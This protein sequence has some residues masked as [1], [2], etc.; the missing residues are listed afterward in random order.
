MFVMMTMLSFAHS[1]SEYCFSNGCN[2]TFTFR[3]WVGKSAGNILEASHRT[4]G[5]KTWQEQVWNQ[6]VNGFDFEFDINGQEII[7]DL[8]GFG[9]NDVTTLYQRWDDIEIN[10]GPLVSECTRQRFKAGYQSAHQQFYQFFDYLGQQFN[11][12]IGILVECFWNLFSAGTFMTL[13]TSWYLT[14]NTIQ[15]LP[16]WAIVCI[17]GLGFFLA[18]YILLMVSWLFY[19]LIRLTIWYTCKSIWYTCKSI[20]YLIRKT[21]LISLKFLKFSI[22]LLSVIVL[23]PVLMVLIPLKYLF[24]LNAFEFLANSC[25]SVYVTRYMGYF[26][27]SLYGNSELSKLL[28]TS[29]L[30]QMLLVNFV[31]MCIVSTITGKSV[32]DM[33]HQMFIQSSYNTFKSLISFLYSYNNWIIGLVFGYYGVNFYIDVLSKIH[34]LQF[35]EK[36]AI[37]VLTVYSTILMVSLML[38]EDSVKK[39]STKENSNKR[40]K[41]SV[42]SNKKTLLKPITMLPFCRKCG[43]NTR[44]WTATPLSNGY[45][46]CI[47]QCTVCNTQHTTRVKGLF[48][49]KGGFDMNVNR[50]SIIK[51]P[52]D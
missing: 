9:F 1:E 40:S 26:L 52:T 32:T 14:W 22:E 23:M 7:E 21:A 47:L 34:T 6:T 16:L 15:L 20:W 51:C 50:L 33:K 18:N 8:L 45:S 41:E 12:L 28:I 38:C 44:F 13:K 43:K 48:S 36:I 37:I 46:D 19:K 5:N 30:P 10:V 24:T 11:V 49:Y 35:H 39:R 2:Q 31:W 27:I 17:G 3:D 25:V 42:K 4:L 29:C